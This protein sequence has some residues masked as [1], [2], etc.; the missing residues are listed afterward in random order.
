MAPPDIASASTSAIGSKANGSIDEVTQRRS[1]RQLERNESTSSSTSA[2]QASHH[3]LGL[4]P[5]ST[6][7]LHTRIRSKNPTPKHVSKIE[8]VTASSPVVQSPSVDLKRE[9]STGSRSYREGISSS[10][11]LSDADTDA[12]KASNPNEDGE[13]GHQTITTD[14]GIY[15]EAIYDEYLGSIMGPLRRLLIRSLRWESPMIAKHQ[16]SI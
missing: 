13:D 3:H 11:R 8:D 15:D 1:R 9:S 4:L 10:S 7:S 12:Y 16:V 14:I 2:R 6:D 5:M